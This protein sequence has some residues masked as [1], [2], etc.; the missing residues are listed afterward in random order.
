MFS[1]P[2]FL[3][4]AVKLIFVSLTLSAYHL[5]AIA[6]G[7][8]HYSGDEGGSRFSSLTQVNRDNV[9]DLELA[10]TYRTGA[11]EANSKLR[12]F[13]DFQATPILLPPEAGG[14]LIVCDPFTKVIALDPATGEERWTHEPKF[15]KVP[16]AGRFKCKGLAQWRDTE[17]KIDAACATRLFLPLPV[18]VTPSTRP[19]AVTSLP[20]WS[21]VPA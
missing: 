9:K 10:W 16:Y 12:M 20:S 13:I 2:Q 18:A 21:F 14:H 1:S 6:Q 17:A 7:W 11:V 5:T 8:P 15:S 4:V 19:P 3:H